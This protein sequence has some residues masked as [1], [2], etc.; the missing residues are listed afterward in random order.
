MDQKPYK[1]LSGL[2]RPFEAGDAVPVANGGTGLSTVA[3]GT[4]L[5]ADSLDTVAARALTAGD[6]PDLE[7]LSWCGL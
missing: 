7:Y 1:L 5:V 4:V 2:H 6:I 3:A